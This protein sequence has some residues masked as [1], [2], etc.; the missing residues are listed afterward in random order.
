MSD[1]SIMEKMKADMGSNSYVTFGPN[2]FQ[3]DIYGPILRK[4][5]QHI[6]ALP[7]EGQRCAL[8]MNLPEGKDR[9]NEF[10]TVWW[11]DKAPVDYH[12]HL[13][14]H[15][16]FLV[17]SGKVD[18]YFNHQRCMLE[19]GDLFFIKPH[20]QHGFINLETEK[21]QGI[22]W[23]EMFEDIRMYFGVDMEMKVGTKYP[24]LLE[25]PEFMGDLMDSLGDLY[26][27]EFPQ[28][29]FTD[30]SKVEW[31]RPPEFAVSRFDNAAGSFLLKIARWEFDGIKE[32]WEIRPKKGLKVEFGTPFGDYPLYYVLEGRMIVEADGVTYTAEAK[33]FI[34]IP[35]WTR[36]TITFPDE[37]TR[38]LDYNEQSHLLYI[39]NHFSAVSKTAP[40]SLSD[41]N[42]SVKP[43]LKKF[44]CHATAVSG[45]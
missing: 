3:P 34:H 17:T 22:T 24:E 28:V 20:V 31:V 38:I 45:I 23:V 42:G 25:D 10:G 15:E 43:V 30:K 18:A 19:P 11:Y 39:L 7:I 16:T 41:W 29:D 35:P 5:G 32:V 44:N 13:W 21:G 6:A 14:G 8:L 9:M 36:I 4:P 37:N 40:G 12:D 27:K 1:K 2:D 26:S 33:D